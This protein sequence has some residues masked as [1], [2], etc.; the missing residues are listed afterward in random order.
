MSDRDSSSIASSGPTAPSL[1]ASTP[2]VTVPLEEDSDLSLCDITGRDTAHELEESI[3]LG[4]EFEVVQ[5]QEDQCRR[6]PP[7]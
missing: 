4:S 3:R 7:D 2:V 5:A 6:T 1:R